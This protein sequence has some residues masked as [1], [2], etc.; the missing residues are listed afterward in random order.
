[1][2]KLWDKIGWI[3]MTVVGSAIFGASYGLFL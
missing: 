1:M 2:K 3:V